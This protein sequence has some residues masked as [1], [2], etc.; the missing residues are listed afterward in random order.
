MIS[1]TSEDQAN[2]HCPREAEK[3]RNTGRTL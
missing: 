2:L 3:V 1:H